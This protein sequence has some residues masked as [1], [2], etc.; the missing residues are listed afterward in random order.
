MQGFEKAWGP[1]SVAYQREAW[2][3]KWLCL[4]MR[5]RQMYRALSCWAYGDSRV[6]AESNA[7]IGALMAEI[8]NKKIEWLEDRGLQHWQF[9]SYPPLRDNYDDDD[10]PV[11]PAPTVELPV[12]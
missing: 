9:A 3:E 5:E 2:P 7:T 8:N 1:K 6:A 10:E 11:T 12:E 4:G